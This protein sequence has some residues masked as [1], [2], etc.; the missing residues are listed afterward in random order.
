MPNLNDVPPLDAAFL[1]V[2]GT[3]CSSS[4]QT[5]TERRLE[6][7]TEPLVALGLNGYARFLRAVLAPASIHELTRTELDVLRALRHGGTTSEVAERLGKSS[8]TVLS[9]IKAACS[10]IGCSGRAAAVSYAVDRG[11]ID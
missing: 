11:W 6:Q 3:I 9:H 8:H 1:N 5:V 10:K 2:I 7:F 4:R